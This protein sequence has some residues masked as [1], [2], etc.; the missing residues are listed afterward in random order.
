MAPGKDEATRTARAV[1]RRIETAALGTVERAG[2]APHVSFV[3]VGLRVDGTPLL[4]LSELAEHTRNLKADPRLS[5]LFDAT[6]DGEVPADGTRLTLQ[7][8]LVPTGSGIEAANDR[9]RYLAR[10]PTAA[11]YA[12]FAD[13]RL[14]SVEVSRAHL[15]AGFG[16]ARWISTTDLLPP[17]SDLAVRETALLSGLAPLVPDGHSIS[18]IDA[19]GIDLRDRDGRSRRLCFD[20]PLRDADDVAE[21]ARRLLVGPSLTHDAI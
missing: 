9:R 11:L 20:A 2:G 14:F 5:L 17:A 1:L 4:L 8:R 12:D 19:D 21:A 16:Q 3:P 13:F 18:G 15:I 6:S 10:H 7:G